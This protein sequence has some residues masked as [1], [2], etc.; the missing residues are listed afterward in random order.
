MVQ[1][2]DRRQLT[3]GC[4]VTHNSTAFTGVIV[5]LKQPWQRKPDQAF[6]DDMAGGELRKEQL[7]LVIALK[8]DWALVRAPDGL[9]WCKVA[10][11]EVM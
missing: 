6:T 3:P 7:G 4:L 1:A 8:D 5:L 11:L 2:Q 10:M 9:G